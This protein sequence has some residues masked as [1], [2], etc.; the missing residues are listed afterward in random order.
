MSV[1]A[2]FFM[3]IG[4]GAFLSSLLW[5][6]LMRDFRKLYHES[7]DWRDALLGYYDNPEKVQAEIHNI[8][9]LHRN[10]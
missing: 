5:D 8:I 6:K 7:I 10:D 2:A 1:E 3:G 9:N 4:I